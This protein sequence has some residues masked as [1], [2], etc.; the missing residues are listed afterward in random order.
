MPHALR[1][2]KNDVCVSA[3]A[4]DNT[5]DCPSVDQPQPIDKANKTVPCNSMTQAPTHTQQ[6]ATNP[7]RVVDQKL[8]ARAQNGDKASFDLLVLKYQGRVG[9]IISRYVSDHHEISD[10]AQETFI[11]AYRGIKNFRSDSAFYTW[12]F[13]IAVNCAKN[14]LASKGRKTPSVDVDIDD[15]EVK[16]N[17]AS[18][19]DISNPADQLNRDQLE[20]LVLRTIKNLPEELGVAL[21]LREFEGLS[22]EEI[23]NVMGCPVGTV[24]SR[25]FRAREAIDKA[26]QKAQG[27]LA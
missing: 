12:L 9:A 4:V 24:R 15:A 21:T 7:E 17:H 3:V 11:K 13:R 26:M 22:Y 25:I 27:E 5:A 8:V 6:F 18:L 20:A 2:V 10:V 23:A 19:Q 1:I 14:Y 16:G